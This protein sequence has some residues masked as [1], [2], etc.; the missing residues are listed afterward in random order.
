M[1]SR[2]HH[3]H[4][5]LAI[6]QLTK[7]AA[8]RGRKREEK[9]GDSHLLPPCAFTLTYNRHK[10]DSSAPQRHE[11]LWLHQK[12]RCC[13]ARVFTFSSTNFSSA[14]QRWQ[15]ASY[16]CDWHPKAQNIRLEGRAEL[17]K[18]GSH[19]SRRLRTCFSA[20]KHPHVEKT[21]SLSCS[22]VVMSGIFLIA[23]DNAPLPRLL[24][25]IRHRSSTP[26]YQL[27]LSQELGVVAQQKK[28]G[29][30]WAGL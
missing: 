8:P 3:V 11:T 14:C 19:D 25:F 13:S 12:T 18:R 23:G 24:F 9:G 20:P 4:L 15:R 1:A 26:S 17:Q 29:L 21:W 28:E 5:T 2:S 30:C 27:I 6:P 10:S 22:R 7:Q 16:Y